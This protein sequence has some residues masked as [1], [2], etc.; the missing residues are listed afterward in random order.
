MSSVLVH[1]DGGVRLIT[2]NRP[3]RLNSLDAPCRAELLDA[4]ERAERSDEIRVV[5]LTGAGRAF[6]TGQD[7][8][9]AEELVDAGATVRDTYNPLAAA[10]RRM[11]KP[12]IAAVNGPAVGAGLG[13]ALCCDLRL[14]A[15]SAY[16]ACSFSR[17]ALVPDTGSTVTLL[18]QLGHAHAFE[19]A[20]TG[21]R[22]SADEALATRLVNEVVDD[23]ELLTRAWE[24]AHTLAAGPA[25]AYGLTKQLLVA[26]AQQDE[27]TVLALEAQYQGLAA[28]DP[29]HAEAVEAVLKKSRS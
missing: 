3:E 2:L 9:A 18:R 7:I 28:A 16:L 27:D 20:Y 25:L 8:A 21:R 1:N 11:P 19:V 13:L 10:L 24:L 6:C 29:A 5:V 14:I 17:V 15:R 4:L 26:A 23:E 22:I 12:A